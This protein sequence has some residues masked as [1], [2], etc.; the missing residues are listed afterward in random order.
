MPIISR[1]ENAVDYLVD[2]IGPAVVLV[3]S[4]V[5]G[6]RQWKRLVEL[7]RPTYQCTFVI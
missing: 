6:N 4:S 7:L 5:S 3:H 1:S 2:G